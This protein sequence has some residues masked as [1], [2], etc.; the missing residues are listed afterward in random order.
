MQLAPHTHRARHPHRQTRR[1][2]GFAR[3]TSRHPQLERAG[4]RP[5]RRRLQGGHSGVAQGSAPRDGRRHTDNPQRLWQ[6]SCGGPR[7][8]SAARVRQSGR[9]P[10]PPNDATTTPRDH[11]DET[12][13]RAAPDDSH[14]MPHDEGEPRHDEN[15]RMT[16]A[17]DD[18]TRPTPPP[19][20]PSAQCPV[21]HGPRRTPHPLRRPATATD[22]HDTSAD[23]AWRSRLGMRARS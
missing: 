16:N 14:P 12:L 20:T 8:E 9:H 17:A 7:A 21:R 2:R 10:T 15:A 11:D 22:N 1:R 4:E 5:L 19:T 3:S 23:A 18:A 6:A 13:H